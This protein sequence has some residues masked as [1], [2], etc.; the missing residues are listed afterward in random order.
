MSDMS[1]QIS[2]VLS[3]PSM[4]EQIKSLSGL[5][6]NGQ[7]TDIPPPV[8][9]PAPSPSSNPLSLAGSAEILPTVMKFMPLLSAYRE[10]DDSVRLIRAIMP[11]LSEQRR[12]RAEQAINLLRIMRVIP[13]IKE[14]YGQGAEI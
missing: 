4:M 6:S 13:K 10:D 5:F 2:R 8:S 12:K 7:Q 1:D 9:P 14:I 3:D 11:F